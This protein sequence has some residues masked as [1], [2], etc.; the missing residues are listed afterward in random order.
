MQLKFSEQ[1]FEKRSN[2]KVHK[3]PSCG[4][5]VG[6]CGQTDRH[7]KANSGLSHFAIAP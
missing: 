6:P 2:I 4:S 3:N 5:R 7:D 1:I